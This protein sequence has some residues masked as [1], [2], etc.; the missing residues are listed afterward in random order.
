M[1]KTKNATL[2]EQMQ[3]QNSL[4]KSYF[5]SFYDFDNTIHALDLKAPK[6][7]R[8][9]CLMEM[10]EGQNIGVRQSSW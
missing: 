4:E 3:I 8:R 6:R 2:S 10:S 5:T 1:K 9:I 7:H